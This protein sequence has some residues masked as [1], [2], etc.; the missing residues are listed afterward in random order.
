MRWP[1]LIRTIPAWRPP[2]PLR[3]ANRHASHKEWAE[4]VSAYDRLAAVDPAGPEKWLLTPGLLRLASALLHQDRPEIAARILREV[5]SKSS[6]TEVLWSI[7][8][9]RL[10]FGFN[11]VNGQVQIK[12][13]QPGSPAERS[14]LAVGD[15]VLKINESELNEKSDSEVFDLLK[16]DGGTKV[17]LEVRRGDG[18]SSK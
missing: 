15:V 18:G 7:P 11:I 6:G 16:G 14:S 3:Q 5:R 10:G 12:L 2:W 17:R 9:Q 13:L 4:A 1:G 8:M